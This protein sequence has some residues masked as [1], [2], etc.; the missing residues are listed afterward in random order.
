MFPMTTRSL[1]TKAAGNETEEVGKLW[2]SGVHELTLSCRRPVTLG[3]NA[4]QCRVLRIFFL[5]FLK[6]IISSNY[7]L[8]NCLCSCTLKEELLKCILAFIA[9]LAKERISAQ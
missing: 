3:M 7:K 4:Q 6:C 2:T 1:M 8:F 9:S 5:A